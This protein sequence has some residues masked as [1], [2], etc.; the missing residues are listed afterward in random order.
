MNS[1]ALRLLDDAVRAHDYGSHATFVLRMSELRALLSAQEPTGWRPIE[2]A[3]TVDPWYNAT[4]CLVFGNCGI[5]FGKVYVYE[6]G[7]REGQAEG[8]SG[9]WKITH[10]MPLPSPPGELAEQ[11]VKP[12]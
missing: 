9:D 10:W 7:T 12:Q 11:E 2:T 1:E 5:A 6:D 4:R 8:F 3:P